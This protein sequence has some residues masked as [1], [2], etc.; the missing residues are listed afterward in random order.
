MNISRVFIIARFLAGFYLLLNSDLAA[1][2]PQQ[3]HKSLVKRSPIIW[4]SPHHME[5]PSS[6]IIETAYGWLVSIFNNSDFQLRTQQRVLHGSDHQNAAMDGMEDD[7]LYA[8]TK[9]LE[10]RSELVAKLKHGFQFDVNLHNLAGQLLD[11]NEGYESSTPA[12]EQANRSVTYGLK[13]VGFKTKYN[14]GSVLKGPVLIPEYE[15]VAQQR[16]AGSSLLAMQSHPKSMPDDF[17][18]IIQREM[19]FKAQVVPGTNFMSD[20][21]LNAFSLR[22][23]QV[24]GF[25]ECDVSFDKSAQDSLIHRLWLP[26]THRLALRHTLG[27][28]MRPILSQLD[29]QQVPGQSLRLNYQHDLAGLGAEWYWGTQIGLMSV[30]S[31]W[32]QLNDPSHLQLESGLYE[33]GFDYHL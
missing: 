21:D 23:R 5:Q 1:S 20:R 18:A 17:K 13:L 16:N 14:D 12:S 6:P 33:L 22:F 9:E 26:L 30:R 25:Y 27:D 28:T 32:A 10:A 4:Q 3:A 7:V 2:S 15:I 8:F 29:F 19:D 24:S 11:R 31:S